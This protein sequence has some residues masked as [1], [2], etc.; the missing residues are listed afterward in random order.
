[1]KFAR[2]IVVCLLVGMMICISGTA[3]AKNYEITV[4][5]DTDVMQ[6]GERNLSIGSEI[7]VLKI[8]PAENIKWSNN[9]LDGQIECGKGV[10]IVIR[11]DNNIKWWLV[12]AM[13]IR[14]KDYFVDKVG[15]EGTIECD[16]SQISVM[17]IW[18]YGIDCE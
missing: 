8:S 18:A 4:T 17:R 1:M 14:G 3:L 7:I 9:L 12:K 6:G 2:S 16:L 13:D 10:K 11:D 15:I 5:N